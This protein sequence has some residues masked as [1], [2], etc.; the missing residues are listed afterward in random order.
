MEAAE[1]GAVKMPMVAELG[2][3]ASSVFP[4]G[5]IAMAPPGLT[6]GMVE[7]DGCVGGVEDGNP[8]VVVHEGSSS[9]VEDDGLGLKAGDRTRKGH[10]RDHGSGSERGRK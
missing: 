9:G 8:G 7:R 1:N 4:S 2:S 5:V 10:R 3:V 6:T